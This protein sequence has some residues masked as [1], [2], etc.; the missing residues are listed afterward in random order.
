MYDTILVPTDG[1]DHAI[2]AAEHSLALA[3]AFDASVHVI[4]VVDIRTH[5]GPFDAG[6]VGDEFIARLEATGEAAVD[7]IEALA[8]EPQT[9]TIETAVVRG[10]PPTA[11]LDY[12]DEHDVDL[13]AMG[14][15][16]RT[17][18]KRYVVGS[19]TERV[20]RRAAMPVLTVHETDRSRVTDTYDDILLPTDGSEFAEAAV[21]HAL[22]VAKQFG[23]RIHVMSAVDVTDTGP[24]PTYTLPTDLMENLTDEATNATEEIAADVRAAGLE[25]TTE[26]RRNI[27]SDAILGYSSENDIDLIAMGTAGRSGLTRY[28]MGSTTER[29]LRHA[30][31]PVLSAKTSAQINHNES[32]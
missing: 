6:G 15:H 31:I 14:T 30:H 18:V 3:E 23:A 5:A 32:E 27:P 21:E 17:G 4:N 13:V 22:A 10:Q 12:A 29:V 28:I 1:S 16:G 11:I 19:V 9:E 2:R 26:V 25:V 7:D 24:T 20:V 8:S